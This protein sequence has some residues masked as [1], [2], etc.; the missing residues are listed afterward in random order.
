MTVDL[1]KLTAPFP[2]EA[3]KQR[4]I[5]GR[6]TADYV[7]GHTV[8]HR[9]NDACPSWNFRI[10]K[11]WQDGDVLKA[12]GELDIPGLGTRQHIGVQKI[13]TRAGEDLHKGHVT[14]A[15][16]KCATLFGVGLELYGPDYADDSQPAP[17]E[18]RTT[19]AETPVERPNGAGSPP[20]PPRP[21]DE[22]P[23]P[24]DYG[25]EPR[26]LGPRAATE[27]QIKAILTIARNSLGL[28]P[29]E[30]D[31]KCRDVYGFPVAELSRWEASQFIDLLKQDKTA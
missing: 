24:A 29:A 26:G 15:L 8:I 31:A 3:I 6:R 16:K 20:L 19:R 9:L 11:E 28:S 23:H 2:K 10:I 18:N 17:A 7:E 5:G 1:K 13:D 27:K 22:P 30:T 4:V 21:R 12:L 14:D 25:E